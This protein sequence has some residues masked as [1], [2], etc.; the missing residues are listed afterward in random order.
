MQKPVLVALGLVGLMSLPLPALAASDAECQKSFEAAD[1][2]NDGVLT[3]AEGRRYFAAM[4]VANKQVS[5]ERLDKAAFIEHCKADVFATSQAQPAAGAPLEGAN[6]FTEGQAKD[7]V[8]AAGF[9][10]VSA[11]QKD[12]KG[13]WRG[14]AKRGASQVNIAVDFKGNVVAQ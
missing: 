11:L 14:T 1:T 9:T 10:E 8:E 13:I 7:R 3:E 12:D 6:S 5:G 4:R 2:N